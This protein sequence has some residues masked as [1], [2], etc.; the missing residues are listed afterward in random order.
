[1]AGTWLDKETDVTPNNYARLKL[2]KAYDEGVRARLASALPGT[3][4][5]P[6]PS[7]E[8]DAWDAGVTDAALGTISYCSA[9]QGQTG[10]V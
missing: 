6:D 2:V 10:P 8:K 9:Y 5:F 1:M 4:P 3:A 7:P